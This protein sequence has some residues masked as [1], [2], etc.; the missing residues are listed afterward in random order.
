[1][2]KKTLL[3]AAILISFAAPALADQYYIVRG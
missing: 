1:M 3:T 2:T